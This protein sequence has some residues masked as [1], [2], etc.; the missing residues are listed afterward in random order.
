MKTKKPVRSDSADG[1]TRPQFSGITL[2][3]AVMFD[4]KNAVQT[5]SMA[6]ARRSQPVGLII[7]EERSI[8][9]SFTSRIS[10]GD[11][12]GACD[13]YFR[14]PKGTDHPRF[15]VVKKTPPTTADLQPPLT[16]TA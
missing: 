10:P 9:F 6:E 7:S 2:R 11:E 5:Q 4:G 14:S 16:K 12:P 8:I 13:R 3:A 1:W 15:D